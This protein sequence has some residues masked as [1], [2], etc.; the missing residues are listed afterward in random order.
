ME[1]REKYYK[2]LEVLKKR[3]NYTTLDFTEYLSDAFSL[4]HEETISIMIDWMNDK[5]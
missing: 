1:N 3:D 4:S 5:K 2:F